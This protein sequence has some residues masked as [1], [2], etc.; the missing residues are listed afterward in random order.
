MKRVYHFIII[1]FVITS[2]LGW[3]LNCTGFNN[4]EFSQRIAISNFP[5]VQCSEWIDVSQWTTTNV[6]G[7]PARSLDINSPLVSKKTLQE[8]Q[9]YIYTREKNAFQVLPY[10]QSNDANKIRF[11]FTMPNS[12][13]IRIVNICLEGHLTPV[14]PQSF[15]LVLIPNSL[16][17]KIP[18]N[19]SDYNAVSESF[20]LSD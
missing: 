15:R 4:K 3:M 20:D 19:M 6:F 10:T 5:K 12:S 7:L 18:V 2:F 11:D 17:Q 9:L 1:V 8:Y 14:E 13:T 16:A